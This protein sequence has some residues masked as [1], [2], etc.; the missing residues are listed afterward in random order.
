MMQITS[1]S[2]LST[3]KNQAAIK[4]AASDLQ[5]GIP[6]EIP[7]STDSGSGTIKG[8]FRYDFLQPAGQDI[9]FT[10]GQSAA[11]DRAKQAM[12]NALQQFL[13]AMQEDGKASS[14]THTSTHAVDTYSTSTS[15]QGQNSAFGWSGTFSFDAGTTSIT[16]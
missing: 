12:T 13:L 4:T 8:E 7:V 1:Q 3:N 10:P 2:T 14:T 6:F 5:S 9:Y 16:A 11:P 15:F